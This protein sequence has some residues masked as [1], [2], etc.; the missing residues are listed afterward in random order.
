MS[1]SANSRRD[2][3][4]LATARR[5]TRAA[6]QL[7]IS[8]GFDGF[9]MDELAEEAGVSRRTLFNYH[10][11]KEEAVLGPDPEV[12]AEVAE[13]FGRGGP[14]GDLVADLAH[15]I[16]SLLHPA[17]GT[18]DPTP[19]VWDSAQVRDLRCVLLRNPQLLLRAHERFEQI[20]QQF[21]ATMANRLCCAPDDR[22]VATIFSVTGALVHDSL[23]E[24]T[25]DPGAGTVSEIF[26]TRMSLLRTLLTATAPT[27]DH[28]T[29]DD[30]G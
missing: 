18:T 17:S 22:R 12:P 9:T 26:Q 25:R 15:V 23:E 10:A 24:F 28:T 20:T 19:F 11:S 27:A 3:G 1:K 7:S 6:Q 30:A 16:E 29:G 21:R 8:R 4:R 14:T 13:E 5:I 2:A